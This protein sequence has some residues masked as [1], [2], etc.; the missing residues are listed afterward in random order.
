[1]SVT[2]SS[3]LG[4]RLSGAR[5]GTTPQGDVR[6]PSLAYNVFYLPMERA[7]KI[8][9]MRHVALLFNRYHAAISSQRS[10]LSLMGTISTNDPFE[11]ASL[12]VRALFSSDAGS[13]ARFLSVAIAWNISPAYRPVRQEIRRLNDCLPF[14][15]NEAT[16]ASM[17]NICFNDA[18]L[19]IAS[20]LP[21]QVRD[22]TQKAGR[23]DFSVVLSGVTVTAEYKIVRASQRRRRIQMSVEERNAEVF[24]AFLQC[25]REH[26]G[27]VQLIPNYVIFVIVVVDHGYLHLGIQYGARLI[28]KLSS[29]KEPTGVKKS[30][31]RQSLL[32]LGDMDIASAPL[33]VSAVFPSSPRT[34]PVFPLVPV[35]DELLRTRC[36]VPGDVA[37]RRP[38][39]LGEDDPS[40]LIVAES[41]L[42]S[43]YYPSI[44]RPVLS[45]FKGQLRSKWSKLRTDFFSADQLADLENMSPEERFYAVTFAAVVSV[46]TPRPVPD[47]LVSLIQFR[48][49]INITPDDLPVAVLYACQQLAATRRN[50]L[51]FMRCFFTLYDAV[52]GPVASERLVVARPGFSLLLRECR[53]VLPITFL[54]NHGIP[55]SME[56]TDIIDFEEPNIDFV[57]VEH[58]HALAD[59]NEEVFESRNVRKKDAPILQL[60]RDT[61][62]NLTLPASYP[63]RPE[64]YAAAAKAMEEID[65]CNVKR[66]LAA[67]QKEA[68]AGRVFTILGGTNR[69]NKLAGGLTG[70]CIG[71]IQDCLR[72]ASGRTRSRREL[73][74]LVM[75]QVSGMPAAASAPPLH[76]APPA[77]RAAHRRRL[78]SM[79]SRRRLPP[80]NRQRVRDSTSPQLP[81]PIVGSSSPPE[82]SSS[83]SSSSSSSTSSSSSLTSS[84]TCSSSSFLEAT[85]SP[86]S[87]SQVASQN[88]YAA[89]P[90]LLPNAVCSAAPLDSLPRLHSSTFCSTPR[91]CIPLSSPRSDRSLVHVLR[92][93][94]Q[95][96]DD[97]DDD[98]LGDSPLPSDVSVDAADVH[99][100]GR[101]TD[102]S[103][104]S[105][106]GCS[107]ERPLSPAAHSQPAAPGTPPAVPPC[108]DDEWDCPN[109]ATKNDVSK[110]ERMFN[111][112]FRN[113]LFTH[114]VR[115]NLSLGVSPPTTALGACAPSA[116][117]GES[118][119]P[120]HL[121]LND[122]PALLPR[123]TVIFIHSPLSAIHASGFDDGP[124]S[125][126]AA[127]SSSSSFGGQFL[128]AAATVLELPLGVE[129]TVAHV[130][131]QLRVRLPISTSNLYCTIA[132]PDT[133]R[134]ASPL[135]PLP[136]LV[137]VS[138]TT[139]VREL[140]APWLAVF[141]V[142]PHSAQSPAHQPAPSALNLWNAM[143]APT[144]VP[145]ALVLCQPLFATWSAKAATVD[146]VY[147]GGFPFFVP[148]FALDSS[149]SALYRGAA[150]FATRFLI[151]SRWKAFKSRFGRKCRTA[152][153]DAAEFDLLQQTC[154]QSAPAWFLSRDTGFHREHDRLRD[155]QDVK[156][157]ADCP[158]TLFPGI[159]G[160]NTTPPDLPFDDTPLH[161]HL[162]R[163]ADS[164]W[165]S[166]AVA[167]SQLFVVSLVWS[168][169]TYVNMFGL[170]SLVNSKSAVT[171]GCYS[172]PLDRRASL[173]L[174]IAHALASAPPGTLSSTPASLVL[175]FPAGMARLSA[176]T[177]AGEAAPLLDPPVVV[178]RCLDLDVCADL[179][180]TLLH[181][182]LPP[183][184]GPAYASALRPSGD[185][186][187]RSPSPPPTPAP[188]SYCLVGMHLG[189]AARD[190]APRILVL[191]IDSQ[192][193]MCKGAALATAEFDSFHFTTAD[194]VRLVY[195][196]M[197]IAFDPAQVNTLIFSAPSSATPG[198][199]SGA[200]QPTSTCPAPFAVHTTSVSAP[201]LSAPSAPDAAQ[202]LACMEFRRCTTSPLVQFPPIATSP[203]GDAPVL[204]AAHDGSH[205]AAAS[206]LIDV[207][208]HLPEATQ[209]D[210]PVDVAGVMSA[211]E[212]EAAHDR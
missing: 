172:S 189:S 183:P 147:P 27:D 90:F 99:S 166:A 22:G 101:T 178:P 136:L 205:A 161:Q 112:N 33:H 96:M 15:L 87:G 94:P 72:F 83:C 75:K 126:G 74:S 156:R 123:C 201:G 115:S 118:S 70:G 49:V 140:N 110:F 165:L 29:R 50:L 202:G 77:P 86:W 65:I 162:G 199:A 32:L 111:I 152:E 133:S 84:S 62:Q 89:P 141:D 81:F 184:S 129:D 55:A 120:L 179:S 146:A 40:I 95:M 107:P 59:L 142:S 169:P 20:E 51:P 16:F 188:P 80:K 114:F 52:F 207:A 186:G 24:F 168:S 138:H 42:L 12:L 4:A 46:G 69:G 182:P 25:L 192:H 47:S 148:V 163:V 131:T 185:L 6:F 36:A 151:K 19:P 132:N 63:S 1:V 78:A 177:S 125:A 200:Q 170:G 197:D 102:D 103:T 210:T 21:V 2:P 190:S 18:G 8:R 130:L 45:P 41:I 191:D 30:V 149:T 3:A 203:F 88:E 79:S 35:L 122:V 28:K 180:R 159:I 128:G 26:Y 109:H 171:T 117:V 43:M 92:S 144:A 113:F 91:P 58:L 9:V 150:L 211:M 106:G 154:Y 14:R 143:V 48:E 206:P 198:P 82:A 66:M 108:C 10:S 37:R 7:D 139:T 56:L 76:R 208:P 175:D 137:P 116:P 145:A 23:A 11:N 68:E 194:V 17:M 85:P 119:P 134:A 73:H 44:V 164:S 61:Y 124:L 181:A 167:G 97:A 193:W 39:R 31:V 195:W 155:P 104:L 160:P 158:F 176:G 157:L 209:A 71:S 5:F 13:A 153:S 174:M 60:I 98:S 93:A 187:D 105:S 204:F 135:L 54:H 64:A 38:K 121:R 196:R 53:T 34:L 173:E 57:A 127:P 67:V 212:I 100:P